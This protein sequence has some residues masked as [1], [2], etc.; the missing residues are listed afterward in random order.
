M[1]SFP[2]NKKF[3]RTIKFIFLFFSLNISISCAQEYKVVIMLGQ[4][5]MVGAGRISD[6]NSIIQSYQ[7]G[8]REKISIPPYFIWEDVE[9][10]RKESQVWKSLVAHKDLNNTIFQYL[11]AF[12]GKTSLHGSELGLAYQLKQNRPD[13]NF[14]FIKIA[15]GGTTLASDWRA[16]GSEQ[17]SGGY[18]YKRFKE[19]FNLAMEQ[20]HKAVDDATI[21]VAGILWMQGEQDAGSESQA[22]AYQDKFNNFITKVRDVVDNTNKDYIINN[23]GTPEVPFILG[24]ITDQE[25][26]DNNCTSPD[27][28]STYQLLYA[29]TVR[30]SQQIVCDSIENCRYF[31]TKDYPRACGY[32]AEIHYD[33]DG[34]NQMGFSFAQHL[35]EFLD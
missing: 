25:S 35:N 24:L 5:N 3:V 21:E 8:I 30:Q 10:N 15:V 16:P 6:L 17:D 28:P 31:E 13:P 7:A 18:M 1:N 4:S 19:D 14:A 22:K 27:I 9:N 20:A 32:N 12:G 29:D 34:L 11:P 2:S 26:L 33:S 23:L